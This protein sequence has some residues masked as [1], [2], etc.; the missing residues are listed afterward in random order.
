MVNKGN[1]NSAPDKKADVLNAALKKYGFLFPE[2]EKELD[3]FDKTFGNTEIDLPDNLVDGKQFLERLKKSG[4]IEPTPIDEIPNKRRVASGKVVSLEPPKAKNDYFKKLVLAAEIANKLHDEPTFGHVK[5]VKMLYLCQEVCNMTLS[6]N[7]GKYA[8]GP[9]DPKLLHSIDAE[10]KKR[11]WFKVVRGDKGIK[12]SLDE[13]N[14]EYQQ[15][16]P[17][18]FRNEL[19][20]IDQVISLFKQ[21]RT[22]FCE[23]VATLFYAWKEAYLQGLAISDALLAERFYAWNISKAK[24]PIESLT[25]AIKWMREND[26]VPIS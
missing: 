10:F 25:S 5:F 9:L 22:D 26:I 4:K 6:T 18:Y 16:Y 24:Y 23:I 20:Q 15:Y 11:K 7:Y 14:S 19:V 21:K 3:E 1:K 2:T 8:A 17:N 13:K 12:Y